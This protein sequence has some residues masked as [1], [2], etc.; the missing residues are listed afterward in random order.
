[1][2]LGLLV[3][4]L[5]TVLAAAVVPSQS[6]RALQG[7]RGADASELRIPA[8]PASLHVRTIG[9]GW[10]IIVLHGGPDFDY[11]YLLPEL[12]RF[13]DAYRLI[14]Y[15]QRGRGRSADHVRPEDV[16]LASDLDDL[17]RVRRHFRLESPV[18]LGHSWGAVLALE[19][20]L[21]HPTRV[22]HLILMNPAPVSVSDVAVLR[23][24]YL[25]RLGSD[26]ARQRAIVAGAAYQAG[27]PEAVAERYRIHFEHALVRPED[28]ETLMARMKAGFIR[29][30]SGGIVKARAVED[31]LMRDTWQLPG[32]DLLPKLRGLD[33]PTL[34]I[35]G[36]Q[37]FIPVEVAQRIAR[38]IPNATFVTIEGCGH[39]AY[40]ECPDEVRSAVDDF[41][42]RTGRKRREH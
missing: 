6:A 36:E 18:I 28:Y 27:D 29:Q 25:E 32:Y 37:D 1:M 8:G 40:L 21:R 34:V 20:A 30:G 3:G 5:A 39:F 7:A 16:T 17:D 26:M 10:P 31:R 2:R 4:S 24:A 33:I 11:G 14:Y 38:A 41:M 12:D 9:G 13:K 42:R 15:D 35:T 19:Y 22:S 23:K